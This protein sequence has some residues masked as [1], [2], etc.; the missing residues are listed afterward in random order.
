[1]SREYNPLKEM[2]SAYSS[3]SVAEDLDS[4]SFNMVRALKVH[5]AIDNSDFPEELA[6]NSSELTGYFNG[7][8][9]TPFQFSAARSSRE[10]RSRLLP[11]WPG[12]FL[13]TVS[14]PETNDRRS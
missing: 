12:S 9:L 10:R 8:E 11:L 14:G 13:C 1:M 6:L 2:A 4:V 5:Q 7:S 3:V